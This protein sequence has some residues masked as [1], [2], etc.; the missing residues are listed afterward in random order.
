MF[1]N[2]KCPLYVRV[3]SSKA[4]LLLLKKLDAIDISSNYQDIWK[5]IIKRPL[6][7]SRIITRLTMKLITNFCNFNKNKIF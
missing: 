1:L 5:N 7:N 3:K 2:K 6:A 4:D